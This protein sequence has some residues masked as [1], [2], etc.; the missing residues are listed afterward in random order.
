TNIIKRLE[1][2]RTLINYGGLFQ[3]VIKLL[4]TLKEKTSIQQD[5]LLVAAPVD[6]VADSKTISLKARW[7]L[8]LPTL[9]PT[10]ITLDNPHWED[11]IQ[12]MTASD[13]TL[14]KPYK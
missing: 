2:D 5:Y 8:M 6:P 1:Q 7:D 3:P 10:V 12:K 11:D 14:D 9:M 13:K 4:C